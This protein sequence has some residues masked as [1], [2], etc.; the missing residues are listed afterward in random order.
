MLH[1]KGLYYIVISNHNKKGKSVNQ[2]DA[3]ATRDLTAVQQDVVR[4]RHV[5][6]RLEP[7]W[8]VDTYTYLSIEF[9]TI[10]VT[11]VK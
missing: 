2:P 11:C 9:N 7:H 3:V 8:K 4:D 5:G 10:C 6:V 1:R